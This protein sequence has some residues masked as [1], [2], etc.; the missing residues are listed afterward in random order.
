MYLQ[1]LYYPSDSVMHRILFPFY[2]VAVLIKDVRTVQEHKRPS[3]PRANRFPVEKTVQNNETGTKPDV[4]S[5]GAEKTE[6][7]SQGNLKQKSN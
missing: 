1:N 7:E 3:G 4:M 6:L 5:R 2:K